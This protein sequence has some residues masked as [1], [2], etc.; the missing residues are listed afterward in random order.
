[1]TTNSQL[2]KPSKFLKISIITA[3]L[4]IFLATLTFFIFNNQEKTAR[5]NGDV[6]VGDGTA[7]SCDENSLKQGITDILDNQILAFD[8]GANMHTITLT[9]GQIDI[10]KS[11]TI[12]GSNL[13]TLAGSGSRI[14]NVLD[15]TTFNL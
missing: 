9:S 6:I 2:K 7:G 13:I 5:A 14:F 15:N 11:F 12:D 3:T 1:M 8:C 10:T 4:V